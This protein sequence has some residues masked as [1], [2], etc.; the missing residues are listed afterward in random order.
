VGA[1]IPVKTQAEQT[2]K[3]QPTVTTTADR[4]CCHPVQA[5]VE[6]VGEDTTASALTAHVQGVSYYC[7]KK[8]LSR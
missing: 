2:R 6:G 1:K 8:F 7:D 5:D 4:L 3:P